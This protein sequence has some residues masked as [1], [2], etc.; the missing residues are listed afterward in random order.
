MY[1]LIAGALPGVVEVHPRQAVV[2][3]RVDVD[4]ENVAQRLAAFDR[5]PGAARRSVAPV[6]NPGA[7]HSRSHEAPRNASC[8][9]SEGRPCCSC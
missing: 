9:P 1:L 5:N 2:P 4:P 7:A 8:C 3:L 6:R